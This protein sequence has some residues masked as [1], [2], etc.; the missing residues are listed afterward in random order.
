MRESQRLANDE[1]GWARRAKG[2]ES[3]I[4]LLHIIRRPGFDYGELWFFAR[5]LFLFAVCAAP[6]VALVLLGVV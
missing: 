3:V 4:H 5:L 6:F 2:G 1:S